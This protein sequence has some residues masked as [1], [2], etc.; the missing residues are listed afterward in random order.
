[1]R[2]DHGRTI[3]KIASAAIGSAVVAVTVWAAVLWIMPAVVK[4]FGVGVAF[5]FTFVM[6]WKDDEIVRHCKHR[7]RIIRDR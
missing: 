1:M 6:L 3:K 2:E 4:M 5:G 7:D